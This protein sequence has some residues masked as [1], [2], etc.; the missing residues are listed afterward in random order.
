MVPSAPPAPMMV[1]SSSI[2]SRTS[3][4]AQTSS[5]TFLMRSSNSPRYFVPATMAGMSRTKICLS[6][7]TSGTSP[8]TMRC[9]SPSTMAV[10]PTPGSPIRQGLFFVLLP[11]ICT[12]RRISS[13]L[14][15]TG[16][17]LPSAAC[18]VK[19]RLKR[20]SMSRGMENPFCT[21]WAYSRNC[22]SSIPR[23]S[24]TSANTFC[25]GT[26]MVCSRRMAAHSGSLSRASRMC[27]V[28]TSSWRKKAASFSACARIVSAR[29]E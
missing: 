16:S 7:M 15:T 11:R 3:L 24:S 1:C 26:P 4:R 9:A 29:G 6:R 19:L 20:S 12:M 5:I 17:S 28:P 25:T 10:L 13:S 14:P 18:W 2:N 27:S 8:L 22:C 23:L 21:C